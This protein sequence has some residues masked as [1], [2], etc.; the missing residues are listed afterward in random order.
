MHLP[1]LLFIYAYITNTPNF[2]ESPNEFPN[3]FLASVCGQSCI[4]KI[5]MTLIYL[6]PPPSS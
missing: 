3:L 1:N 5:L 4:L 2:K 6:K